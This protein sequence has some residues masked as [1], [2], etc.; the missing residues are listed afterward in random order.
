[1]RVV[2][3]LGSECITWEPVITDTTVAGPSLG[4]YSPAGRQHP[5]PAAQPG[6]IL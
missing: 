5:H 4:I 2:G 1:M 6:A 3:N